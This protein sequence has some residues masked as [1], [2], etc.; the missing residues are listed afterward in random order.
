PIRL[1]QQ[2]CGDCDSSPTLQAAL[3]TMIRI[4]WA[5]IPAYL[6]ALYSI[7]PDTNVKIAQRITSVVKEEMLHVILDCNVL[8]A[9]GG[10]PQLNNPKFIPAYPGPFAGWVDPVLTLEKFSLKLL[11]RVFLPIEQPEDPVGGQATNHRTVGECYRLI[12]AGI[13]KAGD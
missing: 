5:T 13:E 11:R 7:K 1:E 8:N 2:M 9:I 3:Q 12:R 4:E 10:Q 6:Y